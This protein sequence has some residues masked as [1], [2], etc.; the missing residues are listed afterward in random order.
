MLERTI[1]YGTIHEAARPFLLSSQLHVYGVLA[2]IIGHA[3]MLL[4]MTL[5]KHVDATA[6]TLNYSDMTMWLR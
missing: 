5:E 3:G 2:I 6:L 4:M 1:L